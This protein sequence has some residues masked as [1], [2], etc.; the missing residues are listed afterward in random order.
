MRHFILA[1]TAAF[2]LLSCSS[3]KNSAEQLSNLNGNWT[4]TVFP[5]QPK[6][7]AEFFNMKTP[8]LQL[9]V[10]NRK[11]SGSTGC[12]RI[13]GGFDLN[14]EEFRFGNLATTKM[15]CP[16]YDENIYMDA[17]NR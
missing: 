1:C 2:V 12:N 14:G 9:D 16:G 6:A 15:G 13:M 8:D 4:L 11:V 7:F 10:P 3:S 17:L 5:S